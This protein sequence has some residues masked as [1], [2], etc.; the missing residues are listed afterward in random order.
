MKKLFDTHAHYNF[1]EIEQNLEVNIQKAKQKNI[2]KTIIVGT[3]TIYNQKA[4]Q[5]G[6]KY[7]DFFYI[8]IGYHPLRYKNKINEF[9]KNNID[10]K[11]IEQIINKD[12]NNL[13][14]TILEHKIH[15]I[16]EIGLDYYELRDKGLKRDTIIF[17]QKQAFKKQ[18]DIAKQNNLPIIIHV[19]DK[20]NKTDAYFDALS[21]IK[22][23]ELN[24]KKFTLHCISGPKKYVEQAL[25]IGA[26]IGF[27]GNITY[28]N[29]DDL[30]D[31]YKF[32]PD[33]YKLLETDAPFLAPEPYKGEINE[34]WMLSITADFL[35]NNYKTNFDTIY[36]NSIFFINH[37]KENIS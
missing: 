19:R 12:I 25:D 11:N 20:N 24:P 10:I 18:L 15:A 27:D 31:L 30:R 6:E 8:S 5:I 2:Q 14:Q 26:F 36:D 17:Y 9:F 13:K 35:Y 21:I 32:V 34:P 16:G 33:E 28:K 23:K 29:A 4:V 3:N 37:A 22:E 1:K 7:P